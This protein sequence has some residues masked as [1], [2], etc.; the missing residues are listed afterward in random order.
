MT[1]QLI[2]GGEILRLDGSGARYEALVIDDEGRVAG[3]GSALAMETLAGSSPERIELDG[4]TVIP[5]LID[6]HP[7]VL[8]FGARQRAVLDITDCKNHAE[9]VDRIRERAAVT[10]PGEWIVTTP[11]GEPHYFVRRSYRDLDERRLPDRTVLDQATTDHPVHIEAWAPRLPNVC[12]FNTA[13][14]RKCALTDTTP[15]RVS[16][17]HFERADDGSLTGILH[18]AVNN[19]YCFDPFWVQIRSHLPGPATWELHEATVEEM[20]DYN[21]RGVTTVFE[22]HNMAPG[23]IAAYRDLRAADR[24]SVRVQCAMEVEGFAYPPW[25]P[26]TV[27]EYR[28]NLEL[29][30]SLAADVGRTDDMLRMSGVTFGQGGPCWPGGI[31]MPDPYTGPYGEPTTGMTFLSPE[32]LSAFVEACLE[33][34]MQANFVLTGYRDHDDVLAELA[35]H[36]FE[37]V[38]TAATE[39][40]W[41]IQHAILITEAHA[42][43]YADYG[44]KLTTCMGFSAAKGDLYGERIGE[45]VWRD[46]VPL[47]RLLNAGLE[48]GL[49]TDWGPKDPW[50]NLVLA[51]THEFWGSGHHNDTADHAV[52]RAEALA[53]WTRDAARTLDWE[54]VGTIHEGGWADLAIVDRDPTA[55]TLDEL[56][57][58]Q[59][60]RTLLGG[61]TVFD[62]ADQV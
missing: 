32:K 13:G 45:W 37:K 38:R 43:A 20:A 28:A 34:G 55:C 3:L 17:V 5:G 27:E 14:L 30:A 39:N 1:R 52:S 59:V 57:E 22:G 7:H 61:R 48:V 18:G 50:E 42:K 31:R 47:K 36:P 58:T 21:A 49:G 23:H 54:G 44:F 8:H 6:T 53:M 40:N 4:A 10:P 33:T 26:L 25:Q 29:G 35:R 60:L 62:R 9:I 24:L 16:D 51:E 56:A 2:T 15:D 46:Q 12:A 41:L 11:V 19:Y